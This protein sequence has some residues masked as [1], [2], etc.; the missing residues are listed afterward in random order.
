[1]TATGRSTPGECLTLGGHD[2]D[3]C[4]RCGRERPQ[5]PTSRP[6]GLPRCK[7]CDSRIRRRDGSTIHADGCPLDAPLYL[8][9][10]QAF[11][12][13]HHIEQEAASVKKAVAETLTEYREA[14]K[15]ASPAD[16]REDD[17]GA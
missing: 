15:Y 2:G 14:A 11:H 8:A 3:P 6:A 13:L 10:M 1:M 16:H 9:L 4:S 7:A 17:R 5:R 12:R